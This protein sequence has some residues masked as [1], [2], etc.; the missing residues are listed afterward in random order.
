[1]GHD[2]AAVRQGPSKG[3]GAVPIRGVRGDLPVRFAPEGAVPGDRIVGIIQPGSGITIY[4]IQ[5]PSL[6]AFD[7][8][9]ERWI[10]VRWDIDEE[11]K[12]R[13]PARI[14]VTAINA[15]GSLAEIAQVVAANDANIHS[16]VDGPHCADFTE[17]TFDLEVLAPEDI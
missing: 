4:P 13:F 16:S 17:M 2:A 3:D 7:D 5:S 10:D 1:V 14:T 6:T 12:E 8:Q 11:R 15:P 9:P